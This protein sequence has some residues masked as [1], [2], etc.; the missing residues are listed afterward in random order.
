MEISSLI[1]SRRTI[2]DFDSRTVAPDILR[3]ALELAAWAPNHRLTLPWAF[4]EFSAEQKARIA[5]M[6]LE[7]KAKKN[8]DLVSNETRRQ[9]E[10]QKFLAVPHLIWILQQRSENPVEQKEDYASVSCGIQNASLFLWDKGI[11]T[12]WTSGAVTMERRLFDLTQVDEQ[13]Y[14]ACGF[15]WIG[16][17]LRVPP[18]ADRTLTRAQDGLIAAVT[19]SGSRASAPVRR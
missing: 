12:K 9:A 3:E 4:F 19:T 8:P 10:R 7:M 14:E 16:F 1:R 5:D 2:H 11:G 13:T 6:A 15:L 18:A 17:P